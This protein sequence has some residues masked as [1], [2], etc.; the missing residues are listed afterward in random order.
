LSS[1]SAISIALGLVVGIAA[2]VAPAPSISQAS[3]QQSPQPS[4]PPAWQPIEATTFEQR[5]S[6][7]PAL[8]P[9][10]ENLLVLPVA[11]SVS[12]LPPRI[13]AKGERIAAAAEPFRGVA[14]LLPYLPIHDDYLRQRAALAKDGLA[15]VD[16]CRKNHL[17]ACAE[18]E[19]ACR[20]DEIDDFQ[21]PE[22][23]PYLE[24]WLAI[25]DKEQS[26]VSLPLP[27]D[28]EWYVLPDTTGHHR[29]KAFAAYAFDLV[30]RVDERLFR[31]RGAALEDFYGFGQTIFA[32]GDGV[33]VSA[34]DHFAD[35][36]PGKVG[37]FDD[38]NGVIVNYGGGVLVDYAHLQKGSA[39]V[40][41]GQRVARGTPLGLVGNSGASGVPH[42]HTSVFDWSYD[43]IRA[44]YH[45]EVLRGARWVAFAGEDL[46]KGSTVR[47]APAAPTTRR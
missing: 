46:E 43:S 30:K 31:G 26:A 37:G 38:A 9:A 13:V 34:D 42:L 28:G 5:E 33:V 27:L 19:A 3:G 7:D 39:K 16:W 2:V 15:L 14:R 41:A 24:R 12:F 25:R 45:G 1:R 29:K 8:K 22:Y 35:N 18:F 4:A 17:D 20:M 10:A 44:R 40:K 11:A 36:P 32:Q 23:K 6:A 21:K 47:N